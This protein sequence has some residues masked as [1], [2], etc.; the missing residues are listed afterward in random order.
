MNHDMK[1]TKICAH[2]YQIRQL[3]KSF[4]NVTLLHRFLSN[5]SKV[6]SKLFEVTQQTLRTRV[7]Q[8]FFQKPT[9]LIPDSF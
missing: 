7:I 2:K 6:L 1:S 3:L 5:E 8:F 9:E 4:I